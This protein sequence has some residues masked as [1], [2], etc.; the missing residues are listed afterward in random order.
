VGRVVTLLFG[1]FTAGVFLVCLGLHV[2]GYVPGAPLSF[3]GVKWLSVA[4]FTCFVAMA[5]HVS[6]LNRA[7][8]ER[9]RNEDAVEPWLDRLIPR[10][11]GTVGVAFFVYVIVSAAVYFARSEGQ[12]RMKDGAFALTSHGRVVREVSEPEFRDAQRLE[13]RGVS[14]HWMLLSAIPTVYFLVV[15][16]RARVSLTAPT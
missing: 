8:R 11:A 16:P 2:A 3:D 4:A 12:P 15:Y 9:V 6:A 5:V 1:L 10:W 7:V 13:V 14:G